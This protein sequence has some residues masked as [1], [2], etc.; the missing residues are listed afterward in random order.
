MNGTYDAN[1]L[2]QRSGDL[3]SV[4]STVFAFF[5]LSSDLWLFT[6]ETFSDKPNNSA[7]ARRSTPSLLMDCIF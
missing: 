3:M 5:I 1:K 2:V 4:S 6:V 7:A